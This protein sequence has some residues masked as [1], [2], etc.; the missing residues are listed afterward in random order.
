MAAVACGRKME[1]GGGLV[2]WERERPARASVRTMACIGGKGASGLGQGWCLCVQGRYWQVQ[3][4]EACSFGKVSRAAAA[5]SAL[6]SLE[7]CGWH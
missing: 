3:G 4:S 7:W 1:A 5:W 6:P 2:E